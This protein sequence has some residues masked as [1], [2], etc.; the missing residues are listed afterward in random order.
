MKKKIHVLHNKTNKLQVPTTT[1]AQKKA[2][3]VAVFIYVSCVNAKMIERFR[4]P[5][6][7]ISAP[8]RKMRVVGMQ[9]RLGDGS[10]HPRQRNGQATR[11]T[12]S[13][14]HRLR[15]PRPLRQMFSSTRTPVNPPSHGPSEE[16]QTAVQA[17]GRAYTVHRP[18]W[19]AA[20]HS[21]ASGS[22]PYLSETDYRL[23]IHL[24]RV[25][26]QCTQTSSPPRPP[27]HHHRE[28]QSLPRAR[29]TIAAR[30]V[31]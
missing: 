17:H 13:R 22:N 5:K 31:R 11:Q 21:E 30:E 28:R 15:S 16:M 25:L 8:N 27:H 14:I 6:W 26:Q 4:Y 19:A 29:A 7:P 1:L 3:H 18:S 23:A 24:P 20:P 12:G 2:V 10:R 9:Y